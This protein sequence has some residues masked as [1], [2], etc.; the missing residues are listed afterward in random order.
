LRKY[1]FHDILKVL[2]LTFMNQRML[3]VLI[4]LPPGRRNEFIDYQK[5]KVRIVVLP[6]R[7][8]KTSWNSTPELLECAYRLREFAPEWLQTQKYAAYWPLFK[9]QDEWTIVKYAMDVL[10]PF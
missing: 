9:T 2:K 7:G 1:V 8:V 6:I 10:R 4:T 5:D 3:A